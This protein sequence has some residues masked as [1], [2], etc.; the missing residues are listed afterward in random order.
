MPPIATSQHTNTYCGYLLTAKK[1]FVATL[2]FTSTQPAAALHQRVF[3]CLNFNG[4]N[5]LALFNQPY[6]EIIYD[7]F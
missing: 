5:H 3:Y 1:R 6:N 2:I 7:N 4:A